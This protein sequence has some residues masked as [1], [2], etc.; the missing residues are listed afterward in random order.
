M[1]KSRIFVDAD[2]CPVQVREIILNKALELKIEVIYAANHN[3]PFSIESP[4]FKMQLCPERKNAADD[5]IVENILENDIAVTKDIPLAQ[6]L[7][8]KNISVI[9]DRGTLFDQKKIQ[10]LLEERELSMQMAALGLRKA[11]GWSAFSKKDLASFSKTFN[12][13]LWEKGFYKN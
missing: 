4:L 7:I 6:R 5:Y 11:A 8:D 2:N 12:N 10:Y 1:N 13:L 9:N 3:I